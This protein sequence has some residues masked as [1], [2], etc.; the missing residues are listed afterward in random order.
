MLPF[1]FLPSAYAGAEA[2]LEV[3]PAVGQG[4]LD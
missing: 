1:C 2:A 4:S 3:V